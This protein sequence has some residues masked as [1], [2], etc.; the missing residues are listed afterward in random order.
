[1]KYKR[2]E[3]EVPKW[4]HNLPASCQ[5]DIEYKIYEIRQ[6]MVCGE[7]VPDEAERCSCGSIDWYLV[8]VDELG[9]DLDLLALLEGEE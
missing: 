6:C 2:S 8:E 7:T 1:M 9:R 5:D 4:D 3:F